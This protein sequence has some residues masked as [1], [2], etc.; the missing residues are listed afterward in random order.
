MSKP[1]SIRRRLLTN[2]VLIVVLITAAIMASTM[3]TSRRIVRRLSESIISQ[4]LDQTE[5]R[6]KQF[7]DPVRAQLLIAQEWGEQ[8]LLDLER[9]D[10]LIAMY[11]PVM[12]R[13]AHIS[14]ALIADDRGREQMILRVGDRWRVRRTQRDKWGDQVTWIEWINGSIRRAA[15]QE[16]LNYDPRTRPWHQGAM[17]LHDNDSTRIFWTEPYKFF[18]T[19]DSGITAS[20]TFVS[21]DGRVYVVGFDVL[22]DDISKFTVNLPVQEHGMVIVLTGDDRMVGLPADPRFQDYEARKAMLL[23]TPDKLGT[24][25]AIDANNAFNEHTGLETDP[26]RFESEG[27]SWWAMGKPMHLAPGR[28]LLI[29]VV[30]PESDVTGSLTELRLLILAILLL[31]MLGAMFRARAMAQRFSEPIEALVAQSDRISRGD[32][33]AGPQVDSNIFE[34]R[35]LAAAHDRMRTG[36]QNLMKLER[37]LQLAQQIQRQT[38]PDQL[39]KIDGF[40]IEAW[41][42]PAD[43][44]GGDAYDVIDLGGGAAVF[45]LAD[46]TGHGIGP[47][48][49]VSQVRS[50]LRMAVRMGG[51]LAS[52][53]QHL[54]EQ[55]RADLPEGRFVTAWLGQ[56]NGAAASLTSFSA[57]QGPLL[58]YQASSQSIRSFNADR[59]PFGVLDEFDPTPNPPIALEHGDI[60]AVI[61]DGIFEAKG[62]ARED[63]GHQRVQEVIYENCGAP[64]SQL[65]EKLR[66]AVNDFTA[67]A[68][69]EDDQTMILI[70]R[71]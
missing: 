65:L 63:F 70:K 39:P 40:E 6:L 54:N 67:D 13:Y 45:L 23:Q 57:G 53:N 5:D 48:L 46:A 24:Q 15:R 36:L 62:P 35:K 66:N 59:V 4:T 51:N 27:Q 30:V 32:L 14:S 25:F 26:F 43:E 37:D 68:P 71:R 8:G 12:R 34:V 31:V 60:F 42:R 64:L 38:F 41:N 9:P 1:A 3:L 44:T 22:L 69:P 18:T 52:I 29:A 50:M 28:E 47:A 55:L 10:Q 16:K 33:N 17:K 21:P 7:F 61:S 2:L 20:T 19:K 58:Y 11:T 49:S 56:L